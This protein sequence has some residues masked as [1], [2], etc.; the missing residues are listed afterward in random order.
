MQERRSRHRAKSYLSG[1][2]AFNHRQSTMGCTVRNLSEDGAKLDLPSAVAVPG[3]FD[4]TIRHKGESRVAQ[5]IWRTHCAIGVYLEKQWQGTVHS[6]E[7]ARRLRDMQAERERLR[8]R[9]A[10]LSEPV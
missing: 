2:I 9:V 6:I 7:A 4:L 8:Q 5:I 10:Q 1:E 3:R